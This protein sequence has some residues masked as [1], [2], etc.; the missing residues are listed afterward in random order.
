MNLNPHRISHKRKKKR[1]E[2]KTLTNYIKSKCTKWVCLILPGIAQVTTIL[3]AEKINDCMT[4]A[5]LDGV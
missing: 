2:K 4:N 1:K 5:I 3:R